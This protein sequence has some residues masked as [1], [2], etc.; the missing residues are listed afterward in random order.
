MI[1]TGISIAFAV[2]A[3]VAGALAIKHSREAQK[4]IE[5]MR[6]QLDDVVN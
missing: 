5:Q 3:V 1:L 6:K 2:V 4:H